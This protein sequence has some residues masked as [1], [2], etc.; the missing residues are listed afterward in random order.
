MTLFP[1]T[2]P[3]LHSLTAKL[4]AFILHKIQEKLS[5]IFILSVAFFPINPA[6]GLNHI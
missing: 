6:A 2:A 3:P 5:D 4:F 1:V